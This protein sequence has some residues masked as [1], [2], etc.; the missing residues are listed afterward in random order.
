MKK[1]NSHNH[2]ILI[3]DDDEVLQSTLKETMVE[4]NFHVLTA[5]SGTKAL[6]IF[7]KYRPDIVVLDLGLPDI[8]GESV[9][10]KLREKSSDINIII[11]TAKHTHHDIVQ[12]L[13]LGADDYITKPFMIEEL[14]ARINT[15]LRRLR[16]NNKSKKKKIADLVMDTE[17]LQVKRGGQAL[18]LTAQEI[19]LLEYFLDN[20]NRVLT[21]DMILNKIWFYPNNIETRVVDVYVGYL[22]KKIDKNF[23][24]KLIHSI[25]GFGYMMKEG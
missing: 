16:A 6:D 3:V 8:S 13:N 2:T 18:D 23:D 17:S 11:L 14:V 4:N 24:K 25:R 10:S 12:G 15:R 1:N 7:E 22:R 20:K 5:D 21:R 9:C 19:R